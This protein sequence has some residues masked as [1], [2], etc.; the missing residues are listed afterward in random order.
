MTAPL[1][2]RYYKAD[3]EV[4]GERS[5]PADPF[6]GVVNEESMHAAVTAYLANQRQGTAAAKN[7]SQVRGGGRK[8]WRQKGTGRARVGSIRSPIW[9][10]GAVIFPPVPRQYRLELPK[11]LGRLARRSA[12]NARAADSRVAVL[13]TLTFE[14]P[15]TRQLVQLLGKLGLAEDKVLILT[16][17]HRPTV[18]LSARNVPNVQV[19]EFGN[20][21]VYD[22]L[23][24]DCV[25]IE[26]GALTSG[27]EAQ[28]SD[29]GEVAGKEVAAKEVSDA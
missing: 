20:A 10:G 1:T 3:G 22:V 7:R 17:E 11:K 19:K 6:D 24:S 2:A 14:Q 21:S 28:Q 16:A 29:G 26:E 25:L 15:K 5:L 23:W 18:Y 8:P 27:G 9:R 13:E 12:F 4:G